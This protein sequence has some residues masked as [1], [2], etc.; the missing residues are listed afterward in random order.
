MYCHG[1]R[2]AW[3]ETDLYGC[4]KWRQR[5]F[6]RNDRTGFRHIE[7]PLLVGGGIQ[8]PEKVYLNAKLAPT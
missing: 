5:P 8:D 3:H 6:D 1:R 7:I 4:R 2:N